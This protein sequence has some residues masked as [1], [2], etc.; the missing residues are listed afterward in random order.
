MKQN[1][2]LLLIGLLFAACK[3]SP[4]SS[5]PGVIMPLK[6]GNQWIG[7][8]SFDSSGTR[9]VRYDTISIDH[10]VYVNNEWWYQT[11]KGDL[12]K[13]RADGLWWMPSG[14]DMY[15]S[16]LARYPANPGDAMR[17]PGSV[18][19]PESSMA[20][21][22]GVAHEVV[23]TNA[24]VTVAGGTFYCYDYTLKAYYPPD[25]RVAVPEE[26]FYMPNIG[27]V[28]ITYELLN[29]DTVRWELLK[30]TLM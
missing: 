27:P 26:R 5:D 20:I 15:G 22:G 23:S 9:V 1:F 11:N 17:M 30:Y 16:G 18:L 7:L 19:I 4:T 24:I 10:E 28:L 6:I 14:P 29:G 8:R 21:S 3:Q 25:A 12:Y 13:N 2:I